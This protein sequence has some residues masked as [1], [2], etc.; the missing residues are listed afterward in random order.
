MLG[1]AHIIYLDT[2]KKIIFKG[3]FNYTGFLTDIIPNMWISMY[4]FVLVEPHQI[5]KCYSLGK[6]WRYNHLNFG[7][8]APVAVCALRAF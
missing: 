8:C 2:K 6:T 1:K 4:L 7:K 3:I 5:K